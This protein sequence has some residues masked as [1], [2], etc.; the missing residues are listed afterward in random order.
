MRNELNVWALWSLVRPICS[1][2]LKT[3]HSFEKK[4]KPGAAHLWFMKDEVWLKSNDGSQTSLTQID[5]LGPMSTSPKRHTCT[6]MLGGSIGH[7]WPSRR[8]SQHGALLQVSW[9][10]MKLCELISSHF[11]AASSCAP[12]RRCLFGASLPYRGIMA[13]WESCTLHIIK[14]K[15][16]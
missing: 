6:Q 3:F 14:N 5:S 11:L 4:K 2:W 10:V 15:L 13:M 1:E 7:M 16:A 9:G 8:R 12:Q